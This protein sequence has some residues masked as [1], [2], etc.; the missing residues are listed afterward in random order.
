M[1]SIPFLDL[2]SVN[3]SMRNELI[4]AV[5]RVIDS[6]WYIGGE[7]LIEFEKNFARYCGTKYC[8]GVANGLD[9]LVLTLRAWKELGK[10]KD[11]DEVIVPANTY[12]AS[13]LAITE[14]NLIPVLVE[15]N[16][17]TYNLCPEKVRSSLTPKTRVLMCVHLY[18]QLADMP[19]L[20]SIAKEHGLLV[21]EDSAQAHG[22]NI[23]SRRAGSWGDASGFSFYPGKNLG[24]L[25]DAGAITTNDSELELTLRAI[26]NYG[27]LE[28]YKSLY[29]GVNSRLDEIQAAMLNVKLKYLADNIAHRREIA[30][31][32][33]NGIVND[34]ISLPVSNVHNVVGLESHVWH[35]FVIRTKYRQQLQNHLNEHGIQ[36][37][38][39]YPIAPHKQVAYV[40]LNNLKLPITESIHDEVLSLPIGPTLSFEQA[41]Y[42]VNVCNFF[43]IG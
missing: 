20:T 10:L 21:L 11:G 8:I 40:G 1:T 23:D 19:S 2:A 12:I 42:I 41:R 38:I 3:S 14:N 30:S 22:A 13:I 39:H 6:G 36:T 26:R 32:Y 17:D 5:T 27:S 25:G 34:L 15:P 4:E 37:L 28:K 18:G 24:A 33:I 43:K 31:I 29:L 35:L 7:E 9:A 16:N